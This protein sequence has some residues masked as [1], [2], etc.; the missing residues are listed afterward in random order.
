MKIKLRVT[1]LREKIMIE[2]I[3]DENN[4]NT[5]NNNEDDKNNDV[6][7]HNNDNDIN[8]GKKH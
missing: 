2:K 1:N 4:C 7:K 3:E 5:N 8:N 6:N